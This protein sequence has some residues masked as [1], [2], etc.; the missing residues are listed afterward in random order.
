[1]M[2][3]KVKSIRAFVSLAIVVTWVLLCLMTGTRRASAATFTVTNT[4]DNGGINPAPGAGTGTLRQ[5]IVDANA[6]AG[7]DTINFAAGVTGTITLGSALPQITQ[8]VTINGP[9]ASVLTVSGNNSFQV[10]N[11][12]SGVTVSISGLKISNGGFP[13]GSG[14]GIFNSGT[15][16][17]TNST[18]SRNSAPSGGGILNEGGTLTVT[19]ST[20][21]GNSA[22]GVGGVPG[23][24]GGIGNSGGT[25]TITNSTLSGNSASEGGGIANFGTLTI[26]NST[27]SGNR[28]VSDGGGILNRAGLLT[29]TNS[30]L[31]GNTAFEGGGID[32]F[33][34]AVVKNSIFANT[35]PN[36]GSLSI[37]AHGVNFS[38]DHTCGA[39]FT[40]VSST[41]A[42]GLNLGPLQDNGG[43]TFTHALLPGS[44]A[45]DAVIPLANCNDLSAMPAPVTTD[46]RGKPRP[47]DGDGD[48]VALCD[49]GA[50]ELQPCT[51][52]CPANI[53]KSNDPN[54]CGAVVTYPAPTT[55]GDLSCGTVT[56]TPPS[57]SFFPVGMTTVNC[58]AAGTA[59][60]PDCSFT[61]TVNDTQPPTITCPANVTAVSAVAC[62]P[63]TTTAVTFPTP[64]ASDNCPGV[65][66]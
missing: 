14:G 34:F 48:G 66:T 33:Q 50:Y 7:A 16:T 59:A 60:N 53:T 38:T 56:C 13:G 18:L 11:I 17:I 9:G 35:F 36:C 57:G 23:E 2:K 54:Q 28:A 27:L 43:P 39:G 51:V 41:G 62:P 32:N 21:S 63:T 20:V 3:R 40:V 4:G 19:N 65:V 24:G 30:T 15:L 46:Q 29:V 37:S 52:T 61:V 64:T 26:T 1:M 12:A 22:I 31:S 10:F 49:A 8:D 42:G 5:A 55:S 47:A 25:L 44:V 58:D 6:M 45:I